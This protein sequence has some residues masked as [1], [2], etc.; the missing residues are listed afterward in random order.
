MISE[1][2]NPDVISNIL[3]LVAFLF[4]TPEIL[5]KVR[6]QVRS[7]LIVGE[8]LITVIGAVILTIWIVNYETAQGA[9]L[10]KALAVP[11]LV[12]AI[13]L[14]FLTWFV[15]HHR[16]AVE[17]VPNRIA[18]GLFS[19]GVGMFLTARVINVA[20]ALHYWV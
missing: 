17:S 8:L 9:S 19:V 2:L 12:Y 13:T 15:D 5:G 20:H 11:T 18:R 1:Y 7:A 4:I 14:F 16:K 10:L 6:G 3:D